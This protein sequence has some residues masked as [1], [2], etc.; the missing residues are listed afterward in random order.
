MVHCHLLKEKLF[1]LVELR[2]RY[3]CV[4]SLAWYWPKSINYITQRKQSHEKGELWV[5]RDTNRKGS[6]TALLL[7]PFQL[8][9]TALSQSQALRNTCV[10]KQAVTISGTQ[11]GPHTVH[12]LHLHHHHD[13]HPRVWAVWEPSLL[14]PSGQVTVVIS[15]T[16][17]AVTEISKLLLVSFSCCLVLH[18][19]PLIS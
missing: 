18:R 14:A 6:C 10:P 4:T 19:N 1:Y 13:S 11:P 3:Y 16:V 17:T 12:T 15:D 7:V 2:D 5:H 9:Q 8:Y